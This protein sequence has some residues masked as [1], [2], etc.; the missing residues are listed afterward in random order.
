MRSCRASRCDVAKSRF[1]DKIR[2]G[3]KIIRTLIADLCEWKQTAA[4]RY[5][6]NAET[7]ATRLTF[8]SKL[9]NAMRNLDR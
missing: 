6:I 4:N 8:G 7:P 5:D 9:T 1:D 2:L 3:V